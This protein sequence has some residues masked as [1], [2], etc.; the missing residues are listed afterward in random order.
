[1]KKIRRICLFGGPGSS[2]STVSAYIYSQLK[3]LGHSV[4]QIQE[5]VK[6]WAYE[7]RV[8][9]S[10]DQVYLLAK[11]VRME[12]LVLRNNVDLVVTDSPVSMSTCYA[13]ASGLA[14]WKSLLELS[15]EFEKEYPSLN[16]FLDRGDMEYQAH[17]RYQT[18]D[19]AVEMDEIIKDLLSNEHEK[20]Y[21]LDCR[22]QEGILKIVLD[23]INI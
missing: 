9:S 15:K 7:N 21:T 11:Q 13:K 14:A 22:D 12:D 6:S 19:E 18:K 3:V 20:F 1:M 10:F 5:F 17:G 16:L 4:E 8:P 23:N 2:K